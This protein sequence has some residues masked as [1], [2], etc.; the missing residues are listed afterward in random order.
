M[1]WFSRKVDGDEASLEAAEDYIRDHSALHRH[2]NTQG[3]QDILRGRIGSQGR[4]ADI[5]DGQAEAIVDKIRK[6]RR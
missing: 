6:E 1:S 4:I 3:V 2:Y 5:S